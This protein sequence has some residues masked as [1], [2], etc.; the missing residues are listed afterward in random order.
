MLNN[1][2]L[3]CKSKIKPIIVKKYKSYEIKC[4]YYNILTDLNL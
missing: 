3:S 1:V 4:V 2:V